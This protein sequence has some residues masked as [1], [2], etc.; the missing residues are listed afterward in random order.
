MQ[1]ASKSKA[2]RQNQLRKL[3]VIAIAVVRYF[4]V[5]FL[6]PLLFLQCI[7]FNLLWVGNQQKMPKQLSFVYI[8]RR[9]LEWA[10]GQTVSL[11]HVHLP[12]SLAHTHTMQICCSLMFIGCSPPE[13]ASKM[14]ACPA[15]VRVREAML[16][17]NEIE[18]QMKCRMLFGGERKSERG[19]GRIWIELKK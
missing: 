8:R 19:R 2:K 14:A 18:T 3:Q 9:P 17:R 15:K 1:I 7:Y 16:K 13:R 6:F 4:F 5:L 10:G 12:H 11:T